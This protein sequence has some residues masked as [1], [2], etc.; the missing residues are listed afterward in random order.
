MD[1]DRRGVAGVNIVTTRFTD[2]AAAQCD[3]L[4]FDAAIVWVP[5]PVQNRTRSELEALA[6]EHFERIMNAIQGKP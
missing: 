4:G 5:H 2:A 3:A 1:L 6:D